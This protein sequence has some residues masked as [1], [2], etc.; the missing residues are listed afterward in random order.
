MSTVAKGQKP[1]YSL[2]SY[3]S[4]EQDLKQKTKLLHMARNGKGKRKD[5]GGVKEE[6]GEES[7][8]K[9]YMGVGREKLEREKR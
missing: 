6:K 2:Q 9:T 3:L 7:G 1:F 4:V 5:G 8:K